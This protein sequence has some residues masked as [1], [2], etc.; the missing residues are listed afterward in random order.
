M[1][2]QSVA[3]W[4]D[5][6]IKRRLFS[7]LISAKEE[8]QL[9]RTPIPRLDRLI[10]EQIPAARRAPKRSSR[11]MPVDPSLKAPKS[12]Q[13]VAGNTGIGTR[14]ATVQ[15]ANEPAT[16]KNDGAQCQPASEAA[17]LELSLIHI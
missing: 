1:V 5:K 7:R 16:V 11:S 14:N 4:A 15:P 8:L 6:V 2:A 12:A 17:N 13:L 10:H 3:V 9:L